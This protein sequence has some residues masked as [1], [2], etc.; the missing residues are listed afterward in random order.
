MVKI[1][2]YLIYLTNNIY[3]VF[4]IIVL[5]NALMNIYNME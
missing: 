2:T 3:I 1:I 4:T 5:N